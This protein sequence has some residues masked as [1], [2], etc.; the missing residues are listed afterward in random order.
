MFQT[1]VTVNA[2]H[3]DLRFSGRRWRDGV[4]GLAIPDI[5]QVHS[6]LIFKIQAV[7]KES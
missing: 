7:L 5:S 1:F 6:A 4:D 2:D 3:K